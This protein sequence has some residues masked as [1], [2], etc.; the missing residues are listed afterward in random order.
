MDVLT[1]LYSEYDLG[2][3]FLNLKPYRIIVIIPSSKSSLLRPI[4]NC[5]KSLIL[6]SQLKE[7][8]NWSRLLI[9]FWNDPCYYSNKIRLDTA[10]EIFPG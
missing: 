10:F 5:K 2:N 7:N 3:I 4:R 6:F 1:S 8:S 9:W